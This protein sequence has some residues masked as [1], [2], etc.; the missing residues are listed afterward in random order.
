MP[1][2]GELGGALLE[3]TPIAMVKRRGMPGALPLLTPAARAFGLDPE[4]AE[5]DENVG[6]SETPPSPL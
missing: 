3:H 1:A 2:A 4:S 5:D 6:P